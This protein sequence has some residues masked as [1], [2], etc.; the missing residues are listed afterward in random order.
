VAKAQDPLDVGTFTLSELA[1]IERIVGVPLDRFAS[2]PSRAR[3]IG[4]L[5]WTRRRRDDPDATL[6][7]VMAMTMSEMLSELG[8]G[9]DADATP[10]PDPDPEPVASGT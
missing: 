9:D 2:A 10:T 6:D 4:A 7:S 5:A 3:L 1:D 8:V